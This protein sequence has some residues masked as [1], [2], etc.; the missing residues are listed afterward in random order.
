MA[1]KKV[2]SPTGKPSKKRDEI[3]EFEKSGSAK[4]GKKKSAYS[5]PKSSSTSK[6]SSKPKPTPGMLGTG[7]A[8][9]AGKAL[10]NRKSNVDAAIKKAGG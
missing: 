4:G 5:K 7:A 2:S 6:K 1:T 8:S 10:K 3:K 9:K